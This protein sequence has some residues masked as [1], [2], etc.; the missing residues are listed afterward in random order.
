MALGDETS[1][2]A[3]FWSFLQDDNNRAVLAW[4]G[5]GIV[6]VVGAV[7]AVLKFLFSRGTKKSVP[8]P[9][10]KAAHGGIA[11]GR[12]IRGNKIDMRG[13]KKR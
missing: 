9:T 2:L 4:I 8:T 10:V 11:A 13:G 6:V 3:H 12:D 7:W 1:M 5:S